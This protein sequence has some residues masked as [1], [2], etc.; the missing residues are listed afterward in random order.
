MSDGELHDS[1]I[2]EWAEVDTPDGARDGDGEDTPPR[3]T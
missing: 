1:E 3:C 2:D